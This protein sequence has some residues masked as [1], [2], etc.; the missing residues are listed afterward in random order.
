VSDIALTQPQQSA[1]VMHQARCTS[2]ATNLKPAAEFR[3]ELAH[4]S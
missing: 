2:V 1:T 3:R 4:A